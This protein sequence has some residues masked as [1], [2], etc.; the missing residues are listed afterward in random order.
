MTGKRATARAVVVVGARAYRGNGAGA[1]MDISVRR[2]LVYE[3]VP[4][5]LGEAVEGVILLTSLEAL[6]AG[7]LEWWELRS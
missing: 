4:N 5:A 7:E 6:E 3:G 2:S 1:E